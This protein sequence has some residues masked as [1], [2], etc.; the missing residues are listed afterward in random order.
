METVSACGAQEVYV[1]EGTEL[2][3]TR[4]GTCHS[5]RSSV[6]GT[7]QDN[8]SSPDELTMT[9]AARSVTYEFHSRASISWS[10]S[11]EGNRWNPRPVLFSFRP[12]VACGA[13]DSETQCSASRP[14]GVHLGAPRSNEY[15]PASVDEAGC[16]AA[17]QALLPTGATQGRTT[18]VA[19]SWGWVPPG[20]SVQSGGDWAAHYNRRASG[21][22][23]GGYSPVC[24][25]PVATAQL[26]AHTDP[27]G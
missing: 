10:S 23:D 25:G 7:G 18:L 11:V 2:E 1:T 24:T 6:V 3:Y 4:S 8:P 14:L 16:L 15:L 21:S 12:Q 5:F 9:Q 19:G 26:V 27:E 17:V 13:S 20:C 22:N